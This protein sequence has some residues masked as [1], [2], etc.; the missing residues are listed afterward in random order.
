[1]SDSEF[2]SNSSPLSTGDSQTL[3]SP[4]SNSQISIAT[5]FVWV[6]LAGFAF[7]SANAYAEFF[8]RVAENP[9]LEHIVTIGLTWIIFL[10]W[11]IYERSHGAIAIHV[12]PL[13]LMIVILT[14]LRD[15]FGQFAHGM[16]WSISTGTMF[17]SN[18][19]SILF[20][21]ESVISRSV[22]NNS[23]SH[24]YLIYR[25]VGG[26]LLMATLFGIGPSIQ[27]SFPAFPWIIGGALIGFWMG[28]YQALASKNWKMYPAFC[29]VNT[30]LVATSG[31]LGGVIIGP[32]IFYILNAKIDV[33]VLQYRYSPLIGFL[34]SIGVILTCRAIG[35][36]SSSSLEVDDRL[37]SRESPR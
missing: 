27:N 20:G 15:S 34:I 21:L 26:I 8:G 32:A 14:L 9:R 30:R 3:P 29:G 4:K 11:H 31:F 19:L 18:V 23:K 36:C 24:Q 33:L 2:S 25:I 28:L 35:C 5:M 6:T 1:M 13:V 7:A 12:V 17:C 37:S 10:I 22:S 16:L